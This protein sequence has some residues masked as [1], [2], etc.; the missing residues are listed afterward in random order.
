MDDIVDYM[1][2][3]IVQN[4]SDVTATGQLQE[5]MEVFA[6]ILS[7]IEFFFEMLCSLLTSGL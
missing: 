3:I 4:D 5:K 6:Y 1:N 2:Y 7:V